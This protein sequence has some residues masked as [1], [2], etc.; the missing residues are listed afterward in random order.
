MIILAVDDIDIEK[1]WSV[2]FASEAVSMCM[3]VSEDPPSCNVVSNKCVDVRKDVSNHISSNISSWGTDG[4]DLAWALTGTCG[5]KFVY[6][7]LP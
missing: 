2:G 3:R 5:I 6:I 4:F 1:N 7:V